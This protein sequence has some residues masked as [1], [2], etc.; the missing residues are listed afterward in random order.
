[1]ASPSLHK[2]RAAL[3]GL[4][5]SM[6]HSDPASLV[7]RL[8]GPERR[9]T[10]RELLR[11]WADASRDPWAGEAAWNFYVHVP[12]CK[13]ICSFCNYKRLRV[14][15]REALEEYVDFVASEAQLLAPPLESQTFGAL[16]VGGGTPSVLSAAQLERLLA[17]LHQRFRFADGAEKT[18]EYDPM[19]MTEERFRVL[20]QY[21]FQRFT[22]GIQ[23]LDVK[24]SELHGRGKQ[25]R[26]HIDRQFELLAQHHI[27]DTNVDFLL[28]LVGTTPAGMIADIDE[29]LRTRRPH[30]MSLYF[31]SPTQ[32]Y[33]DRHFGGDASRFQGF[34]RPFEDAV[35]PTV[36]GLAAELGDAVRAGKHDLHLIDLR[37]PPRPRGQRVPYSYSDLPSQIHRP[38]YLLGIGDSARSHVFARLLYRAEHDPDN[39]DPDAARY[40][41]V[42]LS[43]EDEMFGYVA[44]RF[45]AASC[46]N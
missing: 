39:R 14:S 13:S 26:R 8:C 42:E 43:L 30:E 4:A 44:H 5:A 12:Y 29:V 23:S 38:L 25:E 32:V 40:V 45:W 3:A 16:F 10:P 28:G 9:L 34:L 18:F 2:E 31:L 46:W 17:A 20:A 22:F 33:L 21:G 41:G 24:V 1:M 6:T 36:R 7:W 19:V 35:P 37:A 15:S 11:I 27:R